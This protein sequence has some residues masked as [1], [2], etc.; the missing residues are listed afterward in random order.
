MPLK[1]ITSG[2]GSV[3][4]D[5]NSTASTYTV[6]VPAQG[7]A[8]LTTGSLSGVNASAMS[9][10]T[11]PKARMPTGSILQVVQTV[12]RDAF[13]TTGTAFVDITGFNAT[14]TPLFSTSK[15]LVD[16]VMSCG[17]AG[18]A[19]PA[20]Y[21]NRNGTV[22]DLSD[23]ISPGQRVTIGY[24]NTGAD[25]RDQYLM[26]VVPFKYLDS[27]SSTSA[28]TYQVQMSPMRTASRTAHLNRMN[29]IGDANQMTGISTIT[30]MEIAQ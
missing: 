20:F 19:F 9:V 15:I 6:N 2:G 1:L 11:I 5:A 22:I 28:L 25:T 24:T 13:S 30:L 21:V 8:M 3:I 17:E 4:L 12:K 14:I 29:T 10:G 16:I 18:D 27:P 23:G 7:G 26:T